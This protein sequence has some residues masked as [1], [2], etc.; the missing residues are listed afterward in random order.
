MNTTKL[1][2]QI[3]SGNLDLLNYTGDIPCRGLEKYQLGFT[4]IEVKE[5]REELIQMI[6]R[7]R[8]AVVIQ[9]DLSD[10]SYK[11]VK[12]VRSMDL[13]SLIGNIN[14]TFKNELNFNYYSVDSILLYLRI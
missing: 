4:D 7:D 13:Q 8:N 10:W 6:G 3:G 12:N 1:L 9:I 5:T 2:M 11:E 14:K